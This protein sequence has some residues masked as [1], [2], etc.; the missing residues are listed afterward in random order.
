MQRQKAALVAYK[1]SRVFT[2]SNHFMSQALNCL[3]SESIVVD[4]Q[5]SVFVAGQAVSAVKIDR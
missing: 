5:A 2:E 4:N 3:N 1:Q